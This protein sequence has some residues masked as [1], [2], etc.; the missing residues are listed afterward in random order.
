MALQAESLRLSENTAAQR[1][2]G[3]LV[4]QVVPGIFDTVDRDK[5][6]CSCHTAFADYI[7]MRKKQPVRDTRTLAENQE[8]VPHPV[9]EHKPAGNRRTAVVVAVSWKDN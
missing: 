7:V 1:T 8:A 3:I 6:A 5:A 4:E 9:V 2:S